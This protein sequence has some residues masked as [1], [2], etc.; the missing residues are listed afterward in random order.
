MHSGWC[1]QSAVCGQRSSCTM[2]TGR[3]LSL[4]RT[5]WLCAGDLLMVMSQN[6]VWIFLKSVT[7]QRPSRT[8]GHGANL[9]PGDSSLTICLFPLG[10]ER[11]LEEIL[12]PWLLL[13]S[14]FVGLQGSC[15]PVCAQQ[16]GPGVR[17]SLSGRVMSSLHP[18]MKIQLWEENCPG[19]HVFG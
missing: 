19:L 5:P 14:L 2:E 13:W 9:L 8:L 4:V 1:P 6:I 10:P 12:H 16:L 7:W 17:S 3:P 11:I 18:E 15:A